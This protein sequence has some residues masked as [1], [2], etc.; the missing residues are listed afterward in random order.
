TDY[1]LDGKSGIKSPIS[2]FADKIG[3]ESHLLTVEKSSMKNLERAINRAHLSVERM[4]ASPYASGLATL[5]DDEFELGSVV[6]DMGGG[7]TK[8]AIFDKGKLVYMDVIAIGGSHV[9][10]DLARGL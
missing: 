4:V 2:M 10:N 6:I 5:V 1:A 9:T 3:I 7:T 8:I